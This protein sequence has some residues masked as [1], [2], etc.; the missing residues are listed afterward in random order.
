MNGKAGRPQ[1][2]VPISPSVVP[3][4]PEPPPGS[5]SPAMVPRLARARRAGKQARLKL[6]GRIRAVEPTPEWPGLPSSRWYVV[7]RGS[8]EAIPGIY[9]RWAHVQPLVSHPMI[10]GQPPHL[11]E[12]ATFHGFPTLEEASEYHRAAGFPTLPRL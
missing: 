11:L 4:A 6:D 12:E 8:P 2:S 10:K 3:G 1:S 5:T 9:A 7:L